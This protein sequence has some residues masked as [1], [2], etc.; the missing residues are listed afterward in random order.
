VRA[1]LG[2]V[3]AFVLGALPWGVWLGRAFKGVDV[4]TLGSGNPGATNVYRTL[5]PKLGI[6]T[7][8][9]DVLKGVAGVFACRA[10]AGDA[11]PGGAAVAALAGALASVLGHMWTPFAGFK[12]GK[13]VATGAGAMLAAAPAAAA[14]GLVTFVLALALSRRVSVG[15]ILAAL[16][17]TA[18]LWLV[19]FARA[20]RAT[21]IVGSAIA[22]LLVARHAP[23]I[24]RLARGE[25]P[26]FRF[27]GG[28]AEK[29]A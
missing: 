10:I 19:P 22:A 17:F 1:V 15:S 23:N 16:V 13:G 5:G 9:L 25:E 27:R 21:A 28:G 29:G 14:L 8:A 2:V 20:D 4:R 6:A 24:R 18:A 26:P 12:G 7:F 3:V 11:F